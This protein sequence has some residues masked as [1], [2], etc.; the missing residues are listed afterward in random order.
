MALIFHLKKSY[1][2]DLKRVG[3]FLQVFSLNLIKITQMWKTVI[4]C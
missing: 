1:K 3:K 4:Q 2:L